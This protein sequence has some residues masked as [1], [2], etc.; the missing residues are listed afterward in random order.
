MT[1]ERRTPLQ[2]TEFKRKPAKDRTR[3]APRPGNNFSEKVK[4]SV[5]SRSWGTCEVGLPG[6]TGILE[7]FH[8]RLMRSAGGA[9]T[10]SNCCGICGPCHT[11]VHSHP[12]WS[13]RHGL[14]IRRGRKP[15]EVTAIGRCPPE[16]EEDHVAQ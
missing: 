9:G 12:A 5:K 13:Y 14:L 1:L 6:C 8:H 3:K 7:Q 15:F 16:C 4:R 11:Y 2:R 10:L